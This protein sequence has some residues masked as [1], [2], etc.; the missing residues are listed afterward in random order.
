MRVA[1]VVQAATMRRLAV[2]VTAVVV[3]AEET[4]VELTVR[5]TQAVEVV[6][7]LGI[8]EMVRFQEMAAL[9]DQGL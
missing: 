3:V 9:V 5:L 6:A 1:V 2:A 7:L 8:L 4:L